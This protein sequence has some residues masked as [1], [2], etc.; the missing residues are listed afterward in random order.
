MTIKPPKQPITHSVDHA[1]AEHL[2]AALLALPAE[3]VEG[4]ACEIVKR[5][6]NMLGYVAFQV[7]RLCVYVSDGHGKLVQ[8]PVS[9]MSDVSKAVTA[10]MK[11]D[12]AR[13]QDG[14][15]RQ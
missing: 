2:R 14:E 6:G 7:R 9:S 1:L 8:I 10:L 11:V 15:G 4:G 5:D 3:L 13:S 12:V